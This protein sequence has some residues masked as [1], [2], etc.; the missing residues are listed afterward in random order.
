MNELTHLIVHFVGEL[1]FDPRPDCSD[2]GG[3][4]VS[5]IADSLIVDDCVA[6]RLSGM[7]A[8][9]DVH[10]VAVRAH[11]WAARIARASHILIKTREVC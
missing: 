4:A 2:F 8:N 7:N 10:I 3:H 5:I 9:E 11:Q 6:V 1:L